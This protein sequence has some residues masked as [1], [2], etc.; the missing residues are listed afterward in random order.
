MNSIELS[1]HVRVGQTWIDM[2]ERNT[3]RGKTGKAK[4]KYRTVEIVALP[5]L[6]SPGS[7]R[8]KTAPKNPQSVG[9]LR[10]F[11]FA[12]LLENYAR[13]AA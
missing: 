9:K 7:F 12:K 4:P 2:D 13:L 6:S 3:D 1:N 11:S 8:V 5:S 10:H